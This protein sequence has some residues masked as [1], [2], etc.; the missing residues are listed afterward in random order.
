MK[1]AILI[2]MLLLGILSF[3][4]VYFLTSNVVTYPN[5]KVYFSTYNEENIKVF[6]FY[7]KID[8]NIL[9]DF[10]F[11]NTFSTILDYT[12]R[13]EESGT[14][15]KL[16]SLELPG[17][18]GVYHVVVNGLSS[19]E[20]YRKLFYLTN[21]EAFV[22]SDKDTLYFSIFDLKNKKFLD[23]VYYYSN[24]E[25]KTLNGP[26][27]EYNAIER[28][29]SKFFFVDNNVVLISNYANKNTY[30]PLYK[31]LVITDKPIYKPGDLIHFRVN[32]FKKEGSKYIPYPKDALVSLEDPFNNIIYK[33]NFT[34]DDLGGFSFDYRTSEEIITGN[35]TFIISN[36]KTEDVISEY[37][38]IIQDYKKPTYTVELIPFAT[39]LVAGDTLTVEIK[40]KYLNGDPVKN[41]QIIFYSF[42]NYSRLINKMSLTTNENGK[43]IYNVLLKNSGTYKIQALITDD[44]GYQTE[45]VTYVN[46]KSDNVEIKSSIENNTLKLF[47]TDL[48]GNPLNGI[49]ILIINNKKLY[50]EVYNGKATITLPE[51]VWSLDVLFGKEVKTIYRRYNMSKQGIISLDKNT[52]KLGEYVNI[53]VKP[54][55]DVGILVVGSDNKIWK[56]FLVDKSKNFKFKIPENLF[57][58]DLFFEFRG[59]KYLDHTKVEIKY[60]RVKTLNIKTNKNI[61]K[62]GELINVE[63]KDSRENSLKIVAVADEGLYL[64][65]KQFSLTD[66]LYPKLDFP[67]FTTYLSSKY[68]YF[69]S[70]SK[71]EKN[72]ISHVFTATKESEERNIR[73]Y[74]SETAYWNPYLLNTTFSFK[75]PDNITKWRITVYEIS[76]SYVAQ[77][78]T[79]I[80]TNKPFEVKVFLP[81]FLTVGDRVNGILYIKNYTGKSGIVNI[82]LTAN[83]KIIFNDK[84]LLIEK[85]LKIPFALN[86]TKTELIELIAE[87]EMN[88]EYDGVK[89]DIPVKSI[90]F[91]KNLSYIYVI[92]KETTFK[93][94]DNI[95]II[96]NLKE[97]IE[98][99]I[100]ALIHF[101]YGCVEQTMSSFYPA[102][103]AKGLIE[104]SNLDNIILKGLHRLLKFQHL[105][106][107]WGWRSWDKSDIFMTSY[108][109]EGFYYAKKNGY[110]IPQSVIDEAIKYLKSQSIN[111][112]SA[113]VLKLYGENVEFEPES[114][115]DFVF[116]NPEKIKEIAIKDKDF[117]YVKGEKFYSTIYLTAQSIRTLVTNNKYPDLIKKMVNYLLNSKKGPFWYSTKDTAVSILAILESNVLSDFKSTLQ[118]KETEDSK[119]VNGKGIIKVK[120][121]KILSDQNINNG[122]NLKTNL[123]KRYET[124]FE[125]EYVDT[126]LPL[127]TKFVPVSIK[128]ST[129]TTTQH[130]E[131]PDEI[132]EIIKDGTPI[133]FENNTLII[134]GPFKFIGNEEYYKKGIYEITF[135]ENKDFSIHKNDV[136]KTEID[137]EGNGE[138]L[139][140]EEYLPS[141]AQVIKDY[142]EKTPY[143]NSKYFYNWYKDKKRIWYSYIDIKKDKIVFFIRRLRPGKLVYYWRVRFDGKFYKKPTY[144]Y[145]M[146]YEDTFAISSVVSFNTEK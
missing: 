55:D 102:I 75:L 131:I 74:F 57:E 87:A 121:K 38:F 6:V 118:I 66:Y 19:K 138:Y 90:D 127:N 28:Y 47:I 27:F 43:A 86:A 133:Y 16:Y 115:I 54:K 72:L 10:A 26:I 146:Y 23:K 117:A 21:L 88:N 44:S 95:K 25:K 40:V 33:K 63:I 64:L 104:Y 65:S 67:L 76:K 3:S 12:I 30:Y 139:I 11:S 35:Y 9:N 79:N 114:I 137:I 45:K 29:K 41:A 140:V 107:G 34:S 51:N 98:P 100:K 135:K 106:G 94:T 145:N 69:D 36:L 108:V 18:P 53:E 46:V 112:Y 52:A 144:V 56:I 143:Y 116:T 39:Q 128:N 124:L 70:I 92:N 120:T 14:Y 78:Y 80:V 123:F 93:K 122:I 37:N 32:I 1:R 99:S 97:L 15:R 48:K 110:Y 132:V 59:L 101:P 105:D 20:L 17:D 96:R 8:N 58:N 5:K 109:L 50:V 141:C 13:L 125:D 49:A 89:L 130:S 91:V 126:F 2:L 60:D 61:Y 7:S 24:F 85:D 84:E 111:G 113:F 77:G 136:L 42:E 62:P 4:R 31:A 134:E 129:T 22:A 68:I 103:I 71:L 81:E 83:E 82:N 73:D 142:V 119:I